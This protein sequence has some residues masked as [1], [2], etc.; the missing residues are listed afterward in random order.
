[1]RDSGE[2]DLAT[3]GRLLN[4]PA[5]YVLKCLEEKNDEKKRSKGA[6]IVDDFS[7]VS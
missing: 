6:F 2:A 4:R 7:Y 3:T 5:C 1:M